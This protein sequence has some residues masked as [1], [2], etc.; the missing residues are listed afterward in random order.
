MI[1]GPSRIAFCAWLVLAGTF[2]ALAQTYTI[3]EIGVLKGDNESSGFWLNSAGQV[4]GCSDTAT[5]NGYPCTGMTAGQHAFLWS[6]SAGLKD[7]GTMSGGTISGAIGINDAG[8]VVGYSN[9][10]ASSASDFFAFLWTPGGGMTNLGTLSGGNS[11]CAFE[12]N[13]AGVIAGDSFI[14]NG[15]VNA[16]SWT[17][18]KIR[19][20]G[21]LPKSIFTAALDINDNNQ[22]VGESIF[23]YGPPFRSHA[24]EWSAALGMKDLG[25]LSGGTTS[26]ANA[27]NS[28]GVMVGQSNASGFPNAWHAVMWNAARKIEDLGTLHGGTYSVAFGINDSDEVV[29]YGNISN[30][31]PHAFLWTQAAGM[32]DLNSLIPAN[33]GWVLINANAIYRLGQLTGY[34]TFKGYNHGFLLSPK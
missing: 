22:I 25:T 9:V 4:V 32:R 10:K 2:S 17:N 18:N 14:S 16:T 12:I 34:G 1:A 13:S 6:K 3:T 21:S 11:S 29:G 28:S 20:L 24:V 30:N 19:N 27:I 15:N 8:Q 31:A 5:P 23:S 26:M 7:L 33:S